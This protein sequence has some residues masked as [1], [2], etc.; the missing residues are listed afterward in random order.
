MAE[1]KRTIKRRH[2]IYYLRV[3]DTQSEKLL[4]HVV[5]ITTKGILLMSEK[6][7]PLNTTFNLNMILPEETWNVE[8]ISFDAETLWSKQDVNPDFYVTGFQFKNIAPKNVQLVKHLIEQFGFR[9]D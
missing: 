8:K 9:D 5:D 2:L 1:K 7:L 6:A 4:G 3:F